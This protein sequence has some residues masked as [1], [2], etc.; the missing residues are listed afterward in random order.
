MH[1]VHFDGPLNVA[2][3]CMVELVR[4]VFP[5]RERFVQEI[6]LPLNV[7][8]CVKFANFES[9]ARSFLPVLSMLPVTSVALSVATPVFLKVPMVQ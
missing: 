7:P 6:F 9:L 3:L 8:S 5:V 1:S 2:V 4:I